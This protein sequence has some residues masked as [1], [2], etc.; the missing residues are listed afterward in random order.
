MRASVVLSGGFALLTGLVAIG[1]PVGQL[2]GALR[3]QP[4][5][6]GNVFSEAET[7]E[8]PVTTGG[9]TVEWEAVDYF[10]DVV[11]SGVETVGGGRVTVRPGLV[12]MGWYALRLRELSG[13]GGEMSRIE[14][15]FAV[16]TGSVA[17]E[18]TFGVQTHFAQFT[19]V[20]VME[21]MDR[22][23]LRSFRDDHYWN[24]IETLPGVFQY[25]SRY[26]DFMAAAGSRGFDPLIML[27]WGNS[28]YDWVEGAARPAFY[29]APWTEVGRAGFAAYAL[30]LLAKYPG[31]IGAVEVW[32]EYNAG[33]FINGPATGNRGYYYAKMLQ[34]VRDAVKPAHPAVKIVGGG[35]V[36][37]A[38]GFFRDVFANGGA[39]AMD[40]VSVHPYRRYAEGADLELEEL[41]AMVRAASGGE[42]KPIWATEFSL[43]TESEGERVAGARYVPRILAQ[44]LSA[45]V[46]R[47]Y[48]YPM[49]DDQYFP[50]RGL[51]GKADS[52]RGDYLPNPALV[53]YAV[54]VRELAGWTYG[55]RITAGLAETTYI[56]W[57][58][59]GGERKYVCWGA[60]PAQVAFVTG[61][62]SGR[63]AD[64]MGNE[65]AVEIVEGKLA[66][67]LGEDVIYLTLPGGVAGI[68]EDANPVVADSVSDYGNVQ[69]AGGWQYGQMTPGQVRSF[70]QLG[71]GGWMTYQNRWRS[72][73]YPFITIE[74]AHPWANW[75][76]RR[77]VSDVAGEVRISGTSSVK[78]TT[79]GVRVRILVDGAEVYSHALRADESR[80][81]AVGGVVI[82]PGSVVDFAV[83][84]IGSR[85]GD[86]TEF[87]GRITM[88]DS[89]ASPPPGPVAPMR[90]TATIGN[91]RRVR[92]QWRNS[93]RTATEVQVEK[94]KGRG[95]FRL[96]ASLPGDARRYLPRGRLGR[97]GGGKVVYRVRSVRGMR[98]SSWSNEARARN[99]R[100]SRG[101]R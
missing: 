96:I 69:G 90:L 48:Y 45:G 92:L 80:D 58:E 35:A 62:T 12:G 31:Q 95:S 88:V 54:F 32:N 28:H 3:V 64:I 82:A 71:W 93:T 6:T 23:G 24:N 20:A 61:A 101:G 25:P 38:H 99:A 22:A 19:P 78:K 34:S 18:A 50:Y 76:V 67:E 55:G 59:R 21:L 14:T 9:A 27:G 43:A 53:A 60:A 65:A 87:T 46:E 13:G 85:A 77:W 70:V 44:M 89:T 1:I 37:V 94:R 8:I 15:R 17:G 26:T 16:L 10:G 100:S 33:T 7:V 63:V 98:V 2:E 36:P 91:H 74:Q 75:A 73:D 56:Y 42:S 30:A 66:A 29:T 4:V 39:A 11:G 83:D 5:R 41:D 57:F 49:Q 51:V 68:E 72:G 52:V 79:D 81:Y 40:V 47:A 84:P 97:R 86:A